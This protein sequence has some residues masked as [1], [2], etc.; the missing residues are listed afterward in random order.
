MFPPVSMFAKE[1]F[2][3]ITVRIELSNLPDT[4]GASLSRK[5]SH[6]VIVTLAHFLYDDPKDREASIE[7]ERLIVATGRCEFSDLLNIKERPPVQ[8]NLDIQNAGGGK[9]F[10]GLA[11]DIGMWR[12]DADK[13]FSSAIE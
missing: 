2:Y 11:W 5:S 10:T 7:T 13:T 6:R 8:H 9:R 12:K 4:R 1:I 3:H